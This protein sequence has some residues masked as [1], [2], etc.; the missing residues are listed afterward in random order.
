MNSSQLIEANEAIDVC[1]EKIGQKPR[2]LRNYRRLIRQ[3]EQKLAPRIREW[4]DETI[5]EVRAGLSR[6][7]GKTATQKTKSIADWDA[8][9][10]NGIAILKP[11]LLELL[12]EGGKTVV[13]RRILKQQ[14]FDPIGVEAI[15]WANAHT[16]NLVAEITQ[17][18]IAGIRDVI[19]TGL[20]AGLSIPTIARELRPIVGLNS[21]YAGAVANFQTKLLAE[22]VAAQKASAKAE[23]YANRLHRKRAATI[24]RTETAFALTEGQRQ[25]YGQMG[26][27]RLERVE[28]PATEDDDCADN[29]GRIYTLAEAEGVLPAHPNCEG[30]WVMAGEMPAPPPEAREA[31]P[32]TPGAAPE[33]KSA[34]NIAEA[35]K[36]GKQY[37]VEILHD[38][39]KAVDLKYINAVNKEMS[40]IPKDMLLKIQKNRG[41][42]H[43]IADG[44]ITI[45]PA[46][47]ALKGQ[48][49][50]GWTTGTWDTVPGVGGSTANPTTVIVGNKLAVGHGSVN[51]TLHEYAHTV[52]AIAKKGWKNLSESTQ[53]QNMWKSNNRKGLISSPY[54]AGYAEEYWAESFAE[55]F[56]TV[57]HG[58]L[59]KNVVN[60][61]DKIIK[62]IS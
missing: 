42:V 22:G 5:K 53:W 10:A 31:R 15:N 44:G 13:E 62:E 59:P 52:D 28:D 14:R 8:I 56:N 45:H 48:K 32:G 41:R 2:A 36:W 30:T 34:K 11:T 35:E 1:L 21:Q 7:R 60:Y 49:V 20:N 54:Q 55:Y 23:V 17:E 26:V 58:Y 47:R 3:G 50:R 57:G 40:K 27:K 12:S 33:W 39:G 16:A 61:F 9:E 46:F 29:N 18:T 38:V 19:T 24:A 43:V 25:G 4:M 37:G 6:M 51:L